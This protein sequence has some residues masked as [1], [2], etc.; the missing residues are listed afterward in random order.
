MHFPVTF[1]SGP[2]NLPLTRPLSQ[3]FD[4]FNHSILA[5]AY[6]LTTVPSSATVPESFRWAIDC[7]RL[8]LWDF[9]MSVERELIF[10]HEL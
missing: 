4:V 8:W 2:R 3:Q 1:L 10:R 9:P 7:L 5:P 6:R